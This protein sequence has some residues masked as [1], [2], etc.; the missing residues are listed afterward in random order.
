M[1]ETPAAAIP[2]EHGAT[3]FSWGR[4]AALTDRVA[5]VF[6]EC[7]APMTENIHGGLLFSDGL[8]F[9]ALCD[10]F[11]VDVVVEGGTGFGGST[12]MFARYF[13]PHRLRGIWSVDQ[14]VNPRW[15]WLL[16]ALHLKHYSRFTWSTE[17]RARAEAKVRLAPFPYVRLVRGD[18][19]VRLPRLVARL[20]G[21]QARIGVLLDGPKGEEQ[22]RLADRLLEA[23]DRVRFVALDDIGPMFDYEA[24]GERF[25][26]HP[27]AA[28]ATSER[29]YFDRFGWVN[30]GRLPE[31]MIGRPE[32][33]GYG[34]GILVNRS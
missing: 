8:C 34:M 1:T 20:A 13:G 28:F 7:T 3:G 18:A 14:A 17:K 9:C 27:R 6:V 19:H 24:R 31:R 2:P 16:A 4:F 15:E 10:Y 23:S 33:T 26:A 32:H 5:G 21:Q 12:E 29:R 22:I 25:R 30:Q 11:D